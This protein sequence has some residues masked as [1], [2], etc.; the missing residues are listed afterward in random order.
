MSLF[1]LLRLEVGVWGRGDRIVSWF[2]ACCLGGGDVFV[3]YIFDG[4]VYYVAC[5]VSTSLRAEVVSVVTVE[6]MLEGLQTFSGCFFHILAV[7]FRS[8]TVSCLSLCAL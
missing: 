3:S 6:E 2:L 5:F 4:V 1:V 7:C 8:L